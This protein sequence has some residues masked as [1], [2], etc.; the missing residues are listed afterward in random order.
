MHK[1]IYLSLLISLAFIFTSYSKAYASF[2]FTAVGDYAATTDTNTVL[3]GISNSG[4]AFNLAIGD[5]SYDQM[6]P[7]SSWCTYIKS[8]LGSNYPFELLVGNHEEDGHLS[9]IDNFSNCLPDKIGNIVGTY[10]KEFYF[11]YQGL[12]RFIQISPNMTLDGQYYNYNTGTDHNAWLTSA[13]DSARASGIKWVIV[14]MHEYCLNL[15]DA[16]CPIGTDLPNLLI[17]KNVDLVLEGHAHQYSR[18][19]QLSFANPNCTSIVPG[20]YNSNCVSGLGDKGLYKKGSG[21]VF[22]IVGTGGRN[23]SFIDPNDTEMPYFTTWSGGNI[24][25]SFGFA[26]IS[27]SDS[28]LSSQFVP[29][30]PTS[31]FNDAFSIV[32][33]D[34][35]AN[36]VDLVIKN[37]NWK[38]LD[39]GANIGTTW[40]TST[41]DDSAWK[42]GNAQIGYG[43]GDETTVS[44]NNITTTYFRKT[45]NVNDPSQLNALSLELV[46]DDGAVVY[47]NGIEVVR[48]NMPSGTITYNTLANAY[49]SPPEE[50]YYNYYNIPTSVLIAGTNLI[51]VEVHQATS[52]SADMSFNLGLSGLTSTSITPTP[53]LS[54]SPTTTLTP[55]PTVTVTVTPTP[56]PVV[57]TSTLIP[58]NS[59]WKYIDDG[60]N[61]GTN[62]RSSIFNDSL[63]R[64][65]TA[66]IGYGDGDEVTVI[67]SKQTNYFRKTFNVTD[68]SQ[69]TNL[70]LDIIRDDGAVVYVNGVEVLRSNMPTG[71]I[72][73]DTFASSP[74]NSPQENY[75]NRYTISK[76]SFVSGTN[77]IAVEVH[78]ARNSTDVS[79]NLGLTA[80][81]TTTVSPTPTTTPSVTITPTLTPSVTVTP[82]PLPTGSISPTPTITISPTPTAVPTFTPT[83]TPSPIVTP[84]RF[85]LISKNSVFKYLDNG[86]N[87]GTSWKSN[88]FDDSSWNSGTAQLGYGDGDE[89]TLIRTATTTYFRKSFNVADKNQVASLTLDLIRDDGAVVYINGAEVLRNNMPSGDIFYNTLASA[90]A[91]SPEENYYNTFTISP[92][93]L[94]T[95]TNIIAVEIHQGSGSTDVSFN[96]GLT[97]N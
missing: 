47:I 21:S 58:T 90:F 73:Y 65:G 30:G 57:T 24:N 86:S 32:P 8:Y 64:S 80:T 15:E 27:I 87:Q 56:T 91:N 51:S 2:T 97:A 76:S 48:T 41:Y 94:V 20:T 28:T 7:E 13:I 63:W 60:T 81:I 3:T 29:T 50:N 36:N 67:N 93:S 71:T 79:F 37:S 68:P 70:T 82:T 40:K 5:L 61:Q 75:Y 33:P 35:Y 69:I 89:T 17:R 49:A 85:S 84:S 44:N 31:N 19:K 95:G 52:D 10:G 74:A 39:N 12:A 96:L 1:K 53:T 34:A 22:L 72:L 42:N 38:Y 11:D 23:L 18:S 25:P 83:P 55:T 14:S 26:K 45:F 4:G 66:E 46:R 6:M 16:D 59:N 77:I 88:L 92:S 54:V 62:W 9:Y 78:Q 43:D